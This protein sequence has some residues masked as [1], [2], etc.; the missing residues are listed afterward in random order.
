[1]EPLTKYIPDSLV[2]RLLDKYHYTSEFPNASIFGKVLEDICH[3]YNT[4]T[5]VNPP[6]PAAEEKLQQ[7]SLPSRLLADVFISFS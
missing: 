5:K 2:R 3:E 7:V 6:Q 4:L 1:M